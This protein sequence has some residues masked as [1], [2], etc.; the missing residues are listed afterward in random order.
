MCYVLQDVGR[1]IPYAFLEDV[2]ETFL[3]K[4]ESEARQGIAYSF[5]DQFRSVLEERMKYFSESNEAD[6]INRVRGELGQVR[7]I[8]IENIDKVSFVSRIKGIHSL[9]SAVQQEGIIF[10]HPES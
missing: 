10:A 7:G 8:M 4:H 6:A 5:D 1:R 3:S 9:I 2:K